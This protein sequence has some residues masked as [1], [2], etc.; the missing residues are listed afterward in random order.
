MPV[1]G[2]MIAE[3][4]IYPH[5]L[6][7]GKK[8]FIRRSNARNTKPDRPREISKNNFCTCTVLRV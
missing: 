5:P 3:A 7:L 4:E 1:R 8:T 6:D 2:N